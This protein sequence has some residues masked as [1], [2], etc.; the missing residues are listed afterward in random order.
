MTSVIVNQKSPSQELIGMI[1]NF[2]RQVGTERQIY[3]RIIEK[4]KAENFQLFEITMLARE[5]L[6]ESWTKNQ[7]SK[8]FP[9]NKPKPPLEE[10]SS[11][12]SQNGNNDDKKDT[13]QSDTG[14]SGLDQVQDEI[15]HESDNENV[16]LN[17]PNPNED[18]NPAEDYKQL[19]TDLFDA[20]KQLEIDLDQERKAKENWKIRAEQLEEVEKKRAF[21]PATEYKPGPLTTFQWPEPDESNTFVFRETTFD[22]LR[23]AL[24]PLKAGGNTKINVYLE[25]VK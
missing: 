3:D 15:K 11:G 1:L 24:G 14:S 25:R 13:E 2:G 20:K 9:M 16:D 18:I 8:W 10:S 7:L 12:S 6:K 23:R 5:I 21:T 19:A 22:E 4:G 17:K